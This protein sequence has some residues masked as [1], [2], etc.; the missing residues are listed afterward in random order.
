M[1]TLGIVYAYLPA[2][3]R[4]TPCYTPFPSTSI[5]P[6]TSSPRPLTILVLVYKVLEGRGP[7]S[8]IQVI[9]FVTPI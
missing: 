5:L 3:L 6:L 2:C 9:L 1:A 8:P 7:I 4:S